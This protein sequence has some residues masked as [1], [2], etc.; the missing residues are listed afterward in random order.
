VVLVTGGEAPLGLGLA[1]A[2]AHAGAAVGILGHVDHEVVGAL[3]A[4]GARMVVAPTDLDGAEDIDEAMGFAAERLGPVDAVVHTAVDPVAF[5][6]R[7]MADIDDAHFE[8][9][10]EGTME[11]TLWVM[12]AAYRAFAGRGGRIVVTVP[13]LAMSGAPG[14]VAYAA[15]AEGQRLLAKSA[16]RQWGADGITVNCLAVAPG[17]AMAGGPPGADGPEGASLAAPALE[18][19]G[20]PEADLGPACVFLVGEGGAFVTGAT[21]SLDGGVWMSP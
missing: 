20:D 6:R 7:A 5:E 4:T 19:S 10:W 3:G 9:V 1:L 18:G 8:A 2:L 21:I 13:T 14:L 16:A 15:A 17:L 12:Q 11:A